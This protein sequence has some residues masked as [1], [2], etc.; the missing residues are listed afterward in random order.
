MSG[1]ARPPAT[2]GLEP[3]LTV[4]PMR[5][6]DLAHVLAIEKA[7]FV[8]DAWSAETFWSELAE[9][10]TRRYLVAEQAAPPGAMPG[11]RRIVGYVGVAAIA[12]DAD[13]QTI[14]THPDCRGRG[15]GRTLLRLGLAEAAA[16][17]AR[18][19]H[20]EVRGDNQAAI[21]LYTAEGFRR[22]GRRKGYYLDQSGK[23][24]DAVTMTRD[25]DAASP[26]S[27]KAAAS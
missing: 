20:L 11:G 17:G 22:T 27:R 23:S 9:R 15:L 8:P 1:F 10:D 3:G 14:A 4:R 24:V 7:S 18:R 26:R 5:W 25:L 19:I 2:P 21:G 6:W 13:V 12:D 16:A